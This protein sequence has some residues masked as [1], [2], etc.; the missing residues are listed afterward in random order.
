MTDNQTPPQQDVEDVLELALRERAVESDDDYDDQAEADSTADAPADSDPEAAA[1]DSNEDGED[2][3]LYSEVRPH[4]E[5]LVQ[6]QSEREQLLD[7]RDKMIGLLLYARDRVA[8]AAVASRMDDNLAQLGIELI[9]P[10]VGDRF[11]AQQHEASATVFTEDSALHGTIAEIELAG[12]RDGER[13][14]RHPIVTVF[15]TDRP[16]ST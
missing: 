7:E 10:A 16:T 8:S 2:Y 15:T 14:V 1:A 5:A 12:Y 3:V 11:D 4:L 9:V 6:L 13:L